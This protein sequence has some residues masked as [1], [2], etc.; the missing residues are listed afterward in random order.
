[1]TQNWVASVTNKATRVLLFNTVLENEM[2]WN[3]IPG[4]NAE[5]GVGFEKS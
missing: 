2:K 3:V 1:M 4:C 5:L